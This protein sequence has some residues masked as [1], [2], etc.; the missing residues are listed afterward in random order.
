MIGDEATNMVTRAW[1]SA[2]MYSLN[3]KDFKGTIIELMAGYG[4]NF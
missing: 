3:W 2:F 4:R 1:L